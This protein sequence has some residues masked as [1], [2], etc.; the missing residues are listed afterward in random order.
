VKFTGPDGRVRVAIRR[1]GAEVEVTVVDTGTGIPADFLPFVF[2]PFRQADAT[3]GR[4]HG[5]LGLG[6]AISK[7]LVE[8]H[9]GT[10]QAV[11]AGLG[12]GATVIIRLPASR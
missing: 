9:G 11:S 10:I 5:G 8:L 7:Q 1:S 6:L 3:L 2:E 12:Q 4:G